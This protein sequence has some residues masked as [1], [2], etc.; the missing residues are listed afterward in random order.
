[1][2]AH[3]AWNK[4]VLKMKVTCFSFILKKLYNMR[5]FFNIM[6]EINKY[7]LFNML[8]STINMF[9]EDDSKV[10]IAKYL[11]KNINHIQDLNVYDVAAECFVSRASIRRFSQYLGFDNFLDLKRDSA[12]YEYYKD[13]TYE[14]NYSREL[15]SNIS[16]MTKE[17]QVNIENDLD[18]ISKNIK[19]CN[20]IIFLVSDI[21]SS[22]CQ[23]FQKEMIMLGKMVR[24][25]SHNFTENKVLK[26][27]NENDL[28]IVISVTGGFAQQVNKFIQK[29]KCKKALISSVHHQ[30]LTE[31]YDLNLHLG[32]NGVP[33]KKTIYHSFAVEYYLDIISNEYRKF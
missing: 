30:E 29:L 21:Y 7:G 22:R 15:A 14:S 6:T 31:G 10:I 28:I 3:M 5:W 8:I 17:C 16:K 32:G 9:D 4:L 1:M 13:L 23:E 18:M 27:V 25:V 11:L 24:I 33:R 19:D 2:K 12:D 20:Q 26:N